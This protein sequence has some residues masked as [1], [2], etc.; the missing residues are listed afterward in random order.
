MV[1]GAPEGGRCP[2]SQAGLRVGRQVAGVNRAKGRGKNAQAAR[3]LCTA[4]RRV[5]ACA[6]AS[7]RSVGTLGDL[8]WCSGEGRV[9]AVT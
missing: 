5:A 6:I 8:L 9:V 4:A 7:A 1:H 3:V 2:L